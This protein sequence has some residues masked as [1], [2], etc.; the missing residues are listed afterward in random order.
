MEWLERYKRGRRAALAEYG[1]GGGEPRQP[2]P[3][4]PLPEPEWNDEP[5]P[6]MHDGAGS[7][8]RIAELVAQ[9]A[10]LQDELRAAAARVAELEAQ[11]AGLQGELNAAREAHEK[12]D[13]LVAELRKMN[14]QYEAHTAE[15]EKLTAEMLAERDQLIEV[16]KLPGLKRHLENTYF[17]DKHPQATEAA[18]RVFTEYAQNINAAYDLIKKD[19]RAKKSDEAA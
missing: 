15:L 2:W 9:L 10:G 19:D 13:L 11:L 4:D 6:P 5:A 16:I 18:K 1:I 7:A 17:P 3:D 14:E 12:D 8:A